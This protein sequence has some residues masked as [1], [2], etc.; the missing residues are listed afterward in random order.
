MKLSLKLKITIP[1]VLLIFLVVGGSMGIAYF[2]AARSLDEHALDELSLTVK[3][4]MDL[5]DLWI[6][7]L[8]AMMLKSASSTGYV[9]VLKQD[10]EE[11][12]KRANLELAE[13]TKICSGLS[14]IN[15]VNIRGEVRA[16]SVPDAV[17]KVKVADRE[18]FQKA[19]KGEVNVSTIFVART[20]G[21]PAFAVAA[22]VRDGEKIIGVIV[23]VP[24]LPKFA[25]K[26][27]EPAKVFRSGYMAISDLTGVVFAHKDQSLIMK[28]NLNE[29]DFGREI[30]KFKRG[31]FISQSEDFK[32]MVLVEQCKTVDWLVFAVAPYK[33]VVEDASYTAKVNGI[34]FASGLTLAI[35]AVLWVASSISRQVNRVVDGM[36]KS[37]QQVAAA[38]SQVSVVS[39][40]LAEGS[41][42]HAANMEETSSAL[43]EMA[44][45]TR[46]NAENASQAD[47]LMREAGKAVSTAS[48]SM[49]RLTSSMG[50]ISRASV[51]TQEIIKTIDAIAFQTNLLALN[52]AV[53]AARAGETG[54]G[55]AIVADEVRN[56]AKRAA[57]AAKDTAALIEGTA[58]KVADGSK[59]VETTSEEFSRISVIVA[60]SGGLAGEIAAASSE[61]A[62]GIE[63]INKAATEMDKVLQQT[64]A[65]AEESAAASEEMNA[66]AEQMKEFASDLADLVGGKSK[67]P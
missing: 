34:V 45:I 1:V 2:L 51:Q 55:F 14:Y 26:F 28:L 36:S 59:L 17:G 53:E 22:P 23:G 52:A 16:S 29:H 61:Q 63:Q 60:K 32:K 5:V 46:Q 20:T 50:E 40:Q 33:E 15:I 8:R 57:D 30:L 4:Q 47:R 44:S 35:I 62:Q 7:D 43:E 25:G 24:D 19:M 13:Q 56:L 9:D 18:Y 31:H 39:Q 10:T 65:S 64:A 6:E 38:S 37:A 27:V 21:K 11:T 48:E 67:R 3:S 49:M 54:A 42:E 66:Q 58:L 12:E 41:A